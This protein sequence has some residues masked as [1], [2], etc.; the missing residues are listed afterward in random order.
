MKK[1]KVGMN[2]SVYLRLSILDIRKIVM[3]K[4]WDNYAQKKTLIH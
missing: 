2:R 1:M 4:F 3:C